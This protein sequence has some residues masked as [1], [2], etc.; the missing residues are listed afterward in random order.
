MAQA[1]LNPEGGRAAV[2]RAKMPDTDVAR[3]LRLA[4][5]RRLKTG[6]MAR[7]LLRFALDAA[8]RADTGPPA[9]G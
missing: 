1:P 4:R 8:E 9:G 7:E 5:R 2:V 3:L 6:T